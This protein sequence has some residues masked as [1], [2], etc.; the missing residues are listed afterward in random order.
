MITRIW[1]KKQTQQTIKDLRNN[2]FVV[3]KLD[4]KYECYEE[5]KLIFMAMLGTNTYLIRHDEELFTY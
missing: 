3:D 1:N 2:G 4:N 5:G